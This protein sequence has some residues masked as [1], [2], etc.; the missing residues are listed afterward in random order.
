MAVDSDFS[1]AGGKQAVLD[2]RKFKQMLMISTVGFAGL[3]GRR[4]R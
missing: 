1:G 3:A 2:F 4:W